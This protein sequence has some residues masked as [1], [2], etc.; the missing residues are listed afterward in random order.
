MSFNLLYY[1]AIILF[2]GLFFGKIVSKFKL[3][4]VTGYLIGGILIGP[5][6]LKLVPHTAISSLSIITKSA[7]GFIAFSIG[8]EFSLNQ[9]KKSGFGVIIITILEALFAVILVDLAMIFIFKQSVQFSIVLGAIAA[10][11]APAATVMVIRQYKA[12]GPLVNTLLQVVAMDDAVAIIAFS[13]SLA[14]AQ[15]MNGSSGS[16]FKEAIL[17]PSIE[18]FGAAILGIAA[19]FVLALLS[20]KASGEDQLL[21]ITIGTIFLVLGLSEYFNLSSL[22]ACMMLGATL[23]N[24][25]TNKKPF[26]LADRFTP[27]LFI[28]FFTIAGLDLNLSVMTSIGIIGIGYVVFR[29][30][31][32]LLGAYV[33]AKIANSPGNVQKYLGLALIPQAGV[34]IGLSMIAETALGNNVGLKLK[35]IILAATVIYELFGPVLA[36]I[37]LTKAGE[38]KVS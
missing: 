19:G 8:S 26:N 11:T 13:V 17:A 18:I 12:K 29:V 33:G 10:A 36:K 5:S 30:I 3:P 25:T 32:K 20:K 31:G 15:S 7:L 14:I 27:P 22:I 9:V 2:S 28:A 35:T 6:V 23:V 4:Y 34:A 21:V 16:F 1:V 38:I 37:A 24:I